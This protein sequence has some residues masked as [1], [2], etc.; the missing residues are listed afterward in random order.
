MRIDGFISKYILHV[1]CDL[2]ITDTRGLFLFYNL[3][4]IKMRFFDLI[5]IDIKW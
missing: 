5:T 3:M 4:L 2:L 1:I